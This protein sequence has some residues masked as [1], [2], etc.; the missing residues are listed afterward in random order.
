MLHARYA[1]RK[2]GDPNL[3]VT[4]SGPRPSD[5]HYAGMSRS[6]LRR[7]GEPRQTG[8]HPPRLAWC[9]FVSCRKA[10]RGPVSSPA[11]R[12]CGEVA[13]FGFGPTAVRCKPL[14]VRI[15]EHTGR[16]PCDAGTARHGRMNGGDKLL[17]RSAPATDTGALIAPGF[18]TFVVSYR[19]VSFNRAC[20]PG[21]ARADSERG[22]RDRG[23][24]SLAR[25]RT[26]DEQYRS[27]RP[28][29]PCG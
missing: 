16:R 12:G 13:S 3:S 19:S 28:A 2:R 18:D 27:I 7:S 1:A 5:Q 25:Q 8:W 9:R 26:R 21:L 11:P 10:P 17:R 15:A 24:A 22:F 14:K 4:P 6:C 23:A 29:T 20:Q